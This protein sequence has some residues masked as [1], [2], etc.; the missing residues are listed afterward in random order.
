MSG[1]YSLSNPQSIA[2]RFR[3]QPLGPSLKP[4]YNVRPPD[5]M[6]V[7]VNRGGNQ[8][9][10][11]RWGFLP[12]WAKDPDEGFINARSEHLEQKAAFAKSFATRR[13]VIPASSF[14]AWAETEQ[15][16]VPY[17]FK[18]KSEDLFGMAGLYR[19]WEDP[20]GEIVPTEHE[21]DAKEDVL[22]GI[23]HE[24]AVGDQGEQAAQEPLRRSAGSVGPTARQVDHAAASLPSA[25]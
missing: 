10:L 25:E 22:W 2:P 3:A 6:P 14:F 20:R 8:V 5:V 12:R 7:V 23:G 13:C 16:K 11:L 1:R 24:H 9:E 19:L 17:L 21:E 4:R 18:L 15:G